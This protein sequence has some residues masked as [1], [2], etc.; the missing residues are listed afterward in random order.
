MTGI[1][2]YK[3]LDDF[4]KRCN[5]KDFVSDGYGYLYVIEYG[6]KTKIG[7]TTHIITR[8]ATHERN[9][10]V[11]AN[12]NIGRIA[13]SPL[14]PHIYRY[15]NLLHLAF[16]HKRLSARGEVFD[17]SFEDGVEGLRGLNS[18]LPEDP[19]QLCFEFRKRHK[20]KH[21]SGENRKLRNFLKELFPEGN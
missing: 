12:T 2:K 20:N 17:I 6:S 21:R 8:L 9:A 16:A 13:V 19:D 3:S 5:L 1:K 10:R 7:C 18:R 15:E 14:L 4:I 11:Y